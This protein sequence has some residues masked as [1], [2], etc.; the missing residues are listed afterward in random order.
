MRRQ[1]YLN[2][3]KKRYLYKKIEIIQKILKVLRL[4]HN[5]SKTRVVKK[6][7]FSNSKF[8]VFPNPSKICFKTRIKNYCIVTGRSRGVYKKMR[9]SRIFFRQLGSEGFFFGL[10]KS[11]W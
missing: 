2:D 5:D 6:L 3:N 11:S 10:K 1:T 9:V 4:Y 7:P 8:L